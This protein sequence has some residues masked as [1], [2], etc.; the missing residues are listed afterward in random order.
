[1]NTAYVRSSPLDH[2]L[3]RIRDYRSCHSSKASSAAAI[4][5][6]TSASVPRWN[7]PRL[8]PVA[9]PGRIE[10]GR[11]YWDVRYAGEQ[12]EIESQIDAV[13]EQ[14]GADS[15]IARIGSGGNS[16]D[17]W[18]RLDVL[19]RNRRVSTRELAAEMDISKTTLLEHLRKAESKLL[20]PDE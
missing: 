20:D 19:T 18:R 11:E 6:S 5:R 10:D 17:V 4:A 13:C 16:S 8:S 3:L 9:G 2:L 12:S 1:L 7:P 14:T 15:T